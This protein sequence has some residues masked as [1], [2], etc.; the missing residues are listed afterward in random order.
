MKQHAQRKPAHHNRKDLASLTFSHSS[1]IFLPASK[2]RLI[3]QHSSETIFRLPRQLF[4]PIERVHLNN[5]AF[6][7]AEH[8]PSR[9]PLFHL[10]QTR[11][12]VRNK[13]QSTLCVRRDKLFAVKPR[14]ASA[15][16]MLLNSRRCLGT[17]RIRPRSSTQRD[18][19]RDKRGGGGGGVLESPCSRGHGSVQQRRPAPRSR[20]RSDGRF[21]PLTK[22]ACQPRPARV[23]IYIGGRTLRVCALSIDIATTNQHSPVLKQAALQRVNWQPVRTVRRYNGRRPKPH[24]TVGHCDA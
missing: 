23:C 8:R 9:T 16:R 2:I 11:G 15:A 1:D 5:H 14:I 10:P 3:V 21:L 4:T 24:Y 12:Q 17:Y 20:P 13:E 7:S 19:K 22:A 18:A 6:F